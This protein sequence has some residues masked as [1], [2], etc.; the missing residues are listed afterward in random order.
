MIWLLATP[1]WL[2]AVVA[3]GRCIEFMPYVPGHDAEPK[4]PAAGL[5][6]EPKKK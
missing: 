3:L 2:L 1:L 4:A 5:R 6:W